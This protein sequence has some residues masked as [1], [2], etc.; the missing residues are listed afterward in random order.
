MNRRRDVGQ[1]ER[2]VA[3]EAHRQH[4]V[5]GA[6]LPRDEARRAG[7]PATSAPTISAEPQPTL[8]AADQAPDD[9]EEAGAREA[10]AGQVE[11]GAGPCVSSSR[12]SA[13]G[14]EHE[15]DRDVEP[16]DPVP[17]DARDDRAAD[18]RA[19]RDGETAD[20]APRPSAR[21]RRSAGTAA[22]RI[23]SVSGMTIAP[24]S[25]LHRAS[26]V[27]R[28]DRRRERGGGGGE[29]EDASP[30]ANSRRRPNRSPSAA[31]VSSSTAKVSVYALTVHSRPLEA[32]VQVVRITGM[33]VVTTRL[34][35]VTMKTATEVIA[36]VHQHSLD[37]A[38]FV[39]HHFVISMPKIKRRF[40]CRLQPSSSRRPTAPRR[41]GPST[42]ARSA[43]SRSAKKSRS[44]S[45][46][47]PD[48]R[49]T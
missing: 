6:E 10:E 21:P 9:P 25:A 29:R 47:P 18:E 5:L 1:R 17:G 42:R 38:V 11:P 45:D 7:E 31:P 49:S 39:G 8:V 44:A 46:R 24:P 3:E 23:V 35:S 28:A 30:I 12:S 19:E 33:A 34:S 32:G 36:N 48:T 14:D 16:E 43:A 22:E 13:S 27:E 4:R 20:A 37:L 2:A 15:A 26:D 40:T 41:A